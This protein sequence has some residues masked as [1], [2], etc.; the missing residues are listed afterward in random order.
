MAKR[1]HGSVKRGVHGWDVRWTE[2]VLGSP[3]GRRVQRRGFA[4]RE[5]AEAFLGEKF[6]EREA[7]RG[8][9]RKQ[10]GAATG[11]PG[12]TLS[13]LATVI[14]RLQE[15]REATRVNRATM[16]RLWCRR[17]GAVPLAAVTPTR[18]QEEVRRMSEEGKAASSIRVMV[19]TL[20]ACCVTA[21]RHLGVRFAA[22][23]PTRGL[24]LPRVVPPPRAF[25]PPAAL[26]RLF[27]ECAR[28]GILEEA[29]V[30][31]DTGLRPAEAWRVTRDVVS[32]EGG[33]RIH[34]GDTKT[35]E[36]RTV[37][38]TPRAAAAVA[39]LLAEEAPPGNTLLGRI[40][41]DVFTR[42][43]RRAADAAGMPELAP[44]WLRHGYG[45]GLAQSGVPLPTIGRLLG[46]RLQAT[47]ALY[48]RHLPGGAEEEAVA[49]L[50]AARGQVPHAPGP[51]EQDS[52]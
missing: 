6:Q 38:L 24:Q 46:H 10:A 5:A 32:L 34:V 48:T 35:G 12:P 4:S 36:P 20:G 14:L 37:A 27:R 44:Y 16:I 33:G 39:R 2:P 11:G 19:A 26:E 22:G 1:F 28:E 9:A 43:F 45:S 13:A 23:I 25:L 3:R 15:I 8:M 52:R 47:T 50:A 49:R 7:V 31:A 41:Q 51:S 40:T 18:I 30:L 17:L 42:R 21:E 29:E